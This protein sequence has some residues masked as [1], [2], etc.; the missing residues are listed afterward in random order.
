[1]PSQAQAKLNLKWE[2]THSHTGDPVTSLK[3]AE[4]ARKFAPTHAEQILAAMEEAREPLSF[5]Q[6]AERCEL[7]Y[8]QIERRMSELRRADKVV[9][10]GKRITSAQHGPS[11]QWITTDLAEQNRLRDENRHQFHPKVEE[12]GDGD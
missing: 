4:K 7:K 10:S 8:M 5:E 2:R 3:A 6:I 1:M 12:D 11:V 9:D